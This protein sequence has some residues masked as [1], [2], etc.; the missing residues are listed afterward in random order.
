[1]YLGR[2]RRL[3]RMAA[4]KVLTRE[5]ST[6]AEMLERFFSEARTTSSIR[7][8]GIVEVVDCD[9]APGGAAFIVM[10]VLEGLTLGRVLER[11]RPLPLQDVLTVAAQVA[12]AVSAAH[13]M[14]V[15]HRDLKPEN[16]FVLVAPPGRVKVLDFGIAKL[17]TGD[18]TGAGLTRTGRLMG[19]PVYMSPEQCRGA[20]K[21]D[22]RT[23][24]YALGCILFELAAGVRPFPS[25][26]IGELIAAHLTQAP[27]SLALL[28]PKLPASFV[29]LV[30]SM[31]QKSPEARPASMQIVLANLQDVAA[32]APDEN[33]ALAIAR[34]EVYVGRP[35]GEDDLVT[36]RQHLA[37]ASNNATPRAGGTAFLPHDLSADVG[38][39]KVLPGNLST[40]FS[41][42]AG[43]SVAAAASPKGRRW[44]WLTAGALATVVVVE[45]G[46][47]ALGPEASVATPAAAPVVVEAALLPTVQ[48]EFGHAPA[49]LAVT[50]DG[51]PSVIPVRLPRG[52]QTHQLAFTAPGLQPFATRVDGS[53]DRL[54]VLDMKGLDPQ[55]ATGPATAPAVPKPPARTPANRIVK[56]KKISD[57]ITDF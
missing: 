39:T 49:G 6:S 25:D 23:D 5:L 45:I 12:A 44:L 1:M 22:H 9:V 19:T 32:A 43:E 51:Q 41:Q 56:P 29:D 36:L 34:E 8:P 18:S 53:R 7:H 42:S 4:I 40:T 21:V 27:P 37:G 26:A 24:I 13:A 50:V 15:V 47:R 11:A 3:G 46:I 30:H 48:I 17:L 35:I 10:E 2:H 28:N 38:G 54:L 20:G 52:S 57:V 55:A 31:L 14:G 16:I 33:S